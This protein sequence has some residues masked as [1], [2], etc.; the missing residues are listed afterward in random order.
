MEKEASSSNH[1]QVVPCGAQKVKSEKS[2]VALTFYP[3]EWV[4]DLL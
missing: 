2:K 4:D 1:D 3:I